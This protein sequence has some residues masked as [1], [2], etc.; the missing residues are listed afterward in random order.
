LLLHVIL[1]KNPKP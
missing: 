1:K